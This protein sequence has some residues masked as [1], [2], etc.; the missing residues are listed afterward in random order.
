MNKQL[1]ELVFKKIKLIL[2]VLC[3]VFALTACGGGSG[4]SSSTTNSAP[5]TGTVT[6]ASGYVLK[7]GETA[8]SGLNLSL[9]D[10]QKYYWAQEGIQYG[11]ISFSNSG[12]TGTGTGVFSITA[13]TASSSS[14]TWTAA[15]IAND[16][17][18]FVT[19][20]TSLS[21]FNIIATASDYY[22]VSWTIANT[23]G[24]TYLRWY[25]GSNGSTSA[26]AFAGNPVIT[27]GSSNFKSSD[28]SG[29]TYCWVGGTSYQLFAFN[30]DGSLQY[31][32]PVTSG[33]PG[34][35]L[36][37]GTW[38]VVDGV[39]Q[40]INTYGV[41]SYTYNSKIE[42]SIPLSTAFYFRAIRDNG[43][44]NAFV[45]EPDQTKMLAAAMA[46]AIVGGPQ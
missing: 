46:L 25:F 22:V 39:L 1:V 34:S 21:T 26:A 8:V 32:S 6:T 45:Y 7:T 11:A 3:T 15:L 13:P 23:A 42:M 37:T 20:N 38:A 30:S 2:G 24:S 28:F 29:K 31:S 27:A 35:L 19:D 10:G 41:S 17:P 14:S 12:G 43:S 40:L 5:E 18:I 36:N 44:I 9:L 16:M 4:S 33:S